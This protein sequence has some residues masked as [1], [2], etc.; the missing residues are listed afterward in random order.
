VAI[1]LAIVVLGG[2]HSG[3][4][5]DLADL[6]FAWQSRQPS[7]DIVVVAIDAPSIDQIGVWP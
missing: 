7:G 4:R 6:R 5:H 1:V 3:F 2:W